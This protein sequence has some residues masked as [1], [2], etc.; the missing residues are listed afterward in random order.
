MAQPTTYQGSHVAIFLEGTPAGTY[1]RPCGLTDHTLSFSKNTNTVTV[2]D[3]DDPDLP[4]WIERE[5]ESIDFTASGSGVLAA[6]AVDDW[7]AAFES[8]ATVNARIYVGKPDDTAKGRFW[9]G[10]VHVTGFEVSGTRGNKAQVS[11]SIE[12][13]GELTFNNVV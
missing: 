13:D 8:T 11:V 5:T 1:V 3:C 4:A 7:Y 6:E 10:R 2:P 9:Q 12:S